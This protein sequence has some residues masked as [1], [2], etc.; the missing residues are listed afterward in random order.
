MYSYLCVSLLNSVI[1]H[2]CN[3]LIS[4]RGLVKFHIIFLSAVPTVPLSD[5]ASCA[6]ALTADVV[7]QASITTRALLGA[8]NAE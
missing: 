6:L 2:S 3:K 4:L 5:V 1:I 7:A 8:I